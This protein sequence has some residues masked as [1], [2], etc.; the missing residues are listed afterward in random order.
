M[1][2]QER[3]CSAVP[4]TTAIRHFARFAGRPYG[5]HENVQ[6]L[7]FRIGGDFRRRFTK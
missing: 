6:I 7:N 3:R 1:F 5:N 2:A 4:F